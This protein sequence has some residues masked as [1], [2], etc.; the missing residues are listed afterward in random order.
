M[1]YLKT[2]KLF[3]SKDLSIEEIL[4]IEY[5]AQDIE[6]DI[7]QPIDGHI[8]DYDFTIAQTFPQD[9][10]IGILYNKLKNPVDSLGVAADW[11]RTMVD[12]DLREQIRDLI[13]KWNDDILDKIYV[14]YSVK[15]KVSTIVINS[16]NILVFIYSYNPGMKHNESKSNE[17][18]IIDIL[19][20]EY[21]AYDVDVSVDDNDRDWREEYEISIKQTFPD[22][23]EIGK[24]W[25][26]YNE[27]RYK[28]M[29]NHSLSVADR[30]QL[31]K[32]YNQIR[33]GIRDKVFD[34]ND[35]IIKKINLKYGLDLYIDDDWRGVWTDGFICLYVKLK[36]DK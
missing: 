22:D 4:D 9:S 8:H 17:F 27:P 14:K 32:Q 20:V 3:E 16:H 1:K 10:Q 19:E 15:F 29:T 26:R 30:L 21:E 35:K 25:N 18:D 34:L 23:S 24:L 11:H 2:Y 28:N 6:Y 31:V 12:N 7:R 33:D 5:D 36:G 13:G